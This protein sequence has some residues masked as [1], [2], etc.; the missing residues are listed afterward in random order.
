LTKAKRILGIS[1]SQSVFVPEWQRPEMFELIVRLV[2]KGKP[3]ICY[4]GAARGDDANRI[5][6][7]FE[8]AHRFDCD[9]FALKLFSMMTDEPSEYFK[10]TD[11]IFIDGGATRNLIALMREWD[12][13]EALKRAYES[14]VLIVGASAGISMLFD[15]CISDSIRTRIA[16]VRGIGVLPGTVCAHY[17]V[18]AERRDALMKLL[19]QTPASLPAYGISDGMA[20]LFVDGEMD[21][22]LATNADSLLHYFSS[23]EE[24][25][26]HKEI[27]AETA[28]L[29]L[30]EPS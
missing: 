11:V 23:N 24:G 22:V 10:D 20:V 21:S 30:P 13:I 14:G 2:E 6:E 9:P 16:P 29:K 5:A 1:D 4:L 25:L 7:F 12:A 15:W 18:S 26:S 8:L 28:A 19:Q 17:D 27:F 3:R